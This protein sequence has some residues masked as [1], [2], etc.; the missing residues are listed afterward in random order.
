M[1]SES[2]PPVLALGADF[3]FSS[4]RSGSNSPAVSP[5][6]T[7]PIYLLFLGGSQLNLT[8]KKYLLILEASPHCAFRDCD[9]PG[10][11]FAAK[12]DF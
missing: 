7:N 9:N 1:F 12:C 8:H 3:C 2:V 5:L 6:H 11:E 10:W 4:P